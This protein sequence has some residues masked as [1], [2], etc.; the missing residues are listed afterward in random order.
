M[1]GLAGSSA[2]P[3]I[4]QVPGPSRRISGCIGQVQTE[5]CAGF[6]VSGF[7]SPRNLSGSATNFARQPALQKK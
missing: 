4:G 7:S 1:L 2:M 5:S 3:Q 6:D